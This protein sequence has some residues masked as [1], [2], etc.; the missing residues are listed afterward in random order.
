MDEDNPNDP[1]PQ[2]DDGDQK[3]GETNEDY[4]FRILRARAAMGLETKTVPVIDGDDFRAPS[5]FMRRQQETHRQT[6]IEEHERLHRERLSQQGPNYDEIYSRG[7]YDTRQKRREANAAR[8]ASALADA[9]QWDVRHNHDPN[10]RRTPVRNDGYN[11]G[12][13]LVGLFL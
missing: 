4:V 1:R 8:R 3:P 12:D 5:A 9:R 11:S 2:Y 7:W 6:T 10:L 13:D